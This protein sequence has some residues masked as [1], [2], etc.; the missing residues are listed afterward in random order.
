MALAGL[1]IAFDTLGG[2]A[3][4]LSPPAVAKLGMPIP[5]MLNDNG[6]RAFSRVII[7]AVMGVVGTAIVRYVSLSVVFCEGGLT[8]VSR[9]QAS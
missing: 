3:R 6:F 5:I 9:E 2:R 8:Q 7:L 1:V 4:A